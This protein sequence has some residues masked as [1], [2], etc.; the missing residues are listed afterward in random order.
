[1]FNIGDAVIFFEDERELER[2]LNRWKTTEK[3]FKECAVYYLLDY[4]ENHVVINHNKDATIDSESNITVN[5]E[6]YLICNKETIDAELLSIN[7][8]RYAVCKKIKEL[9]HKHNRNHG[10][11][12]KFQG[13]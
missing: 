6:N 9:Y 11:V 8:P 10:D 5:R 3:I 4:D 2:Q 13:I 12:F 7:N 1:M